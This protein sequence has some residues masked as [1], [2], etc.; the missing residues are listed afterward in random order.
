MSAK[1]SSSVNPTLRRGPRKAA[2]MRVCHAVF[3]GCVIL[4]CPLRC[5]ASVI[6]FTDRAAFNAHGVVSSPSTFDAVFVARDTLPAR[7]TPF[8]DYHGP[9]TQDGVTYTPLLTYLMVL[10]SGPTGPVGAGPKLIGV[11][12]FGFPMD[13]RPQ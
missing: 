12:D 7:E 1:N 9:Y 4:A 2:P 13:I 5:A 3:Y 6:T 10:A 8:G 11:L